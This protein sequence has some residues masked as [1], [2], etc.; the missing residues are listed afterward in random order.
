[1]VVRPDLSA[2]FAALGADELRLDVAEPDVIA[3]GI[4]ADL[5]VMAGYWPK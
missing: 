2:T 3:P 1:M 5:G 4:G